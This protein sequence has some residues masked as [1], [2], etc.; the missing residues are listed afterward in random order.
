MW[1]KE[2]IPQRRW[3][4]R[5]EW[6]LLARVPGTL[7]PSPYSLHRC[8]EIWPQVILFPCFHASLMPVD[9]PLV[10]ERLE[11]EI[12]VIAADA[13]VAHAAERELVLQVVREHAVDGDAA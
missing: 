8:V 7:L 13:A 6:D 2:L 9:G 5:L 4:R 11:A 1:G 12:A 3:P 10:R